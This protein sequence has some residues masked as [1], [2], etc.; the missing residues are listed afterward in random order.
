M[1]FWLFLKR[2]LTVDDSIVDET[3]SLGYRPLGERMDDDQWS[4][5]RPEGEISAA[6]AGAETGTS[7]AAD[8]ADSCKSDAG[9]ADAGKARA[10][11]AGAAGGKGGAS[12]ANAGNAGAGDGEREKKTVTAK[13]ERGNTGEKGTPFKRPTPLVAEKRERAE[14]MSPEEALQQPVS[15]NLEVNLALVKTALRVPKNKDIIIREFVIGNPGVRAFTVYLEG[16]S[17][18]HT[19]DFAILEPLMLL[20]YIEGPLPEGKSIFDL[21]KDKLLPGNQVREHDQIQPLLQAAL[22]GDTALFIDEQNRGLVIESKGWDR[23]SPDKPVTEQV[24]RGPQEAFVETLRTNTALIRRRLRTPALVTE[25]VQ[26][27]QLSK[28]DIAI[29][30]IDGITNP[31]L[32]D[33]VKRRIE[34]IDTDFLP[35]SGMVEEYI[36]DSPR[37]LFPGVMLTERPDRSASFLAEGHVV[38]LVDTSPFALIVP[39]TFITMMH[40]AEDYYIKYPFGTF[41][42]LIRMISLFAALLAPALY[43]AI[44]NYHQEMIPTDL[45]LSIAASRETVPF[46]VVLE[47]LLME[48]SFELI[49]EAGIRIPGP[50]GPTIGIVGAL[51][52]GQAAVQANIVSPILVIVVAITALS[53]FAIPNLNLTFSVRIFRF[54]FILAASVMGLYGI[55]LCLFALIIRMTSLKS[56]GVPFMSPLAPSRPAGDLVLRHPLWQMR[57]RPAYL[58]PLDDVR[59]DKMNRSWAPS[60]DTIKEAAPKRGKKAK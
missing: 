18:R 10:D 12:A 26:G 1:G 44:A 3:F 2:L 4:P 41:L 53:S 31:K 33:E 48:F 25:L 36:E 46:P 52:L 29:M 15:S 55:A 9:A 58:R 28:I 57:R 24:L 20:S 19:V 59:Q 16:I 11:A 60:P 43:I 23:R 22:V 50:I 38:V 49:R 56:F 30:Y 27:G 13:D 51:I 35:E 14:A 47:V 42:R 5:R 54:G 34:S 7:G 8:A 21:V 6:E 32:I 45:M 39:V 37:S 40:S 17:E